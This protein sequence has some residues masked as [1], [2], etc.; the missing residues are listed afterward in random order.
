M[1]CSYHFGPFRIDTADRVLLRDG[2]PVL[3]TPKAVDVLVALLSSKGRVLDKDALL[4][5]AWPG[6]FVE[7][8]N[9]AQN[10]SLLRKALGDLRDA[11]RYIETIPKRGYRFVGTVRESRGEET[12]PPVSA[13][14]NSIAVLPFVDMSPTGDQEYLSDGLTEELIHEL[15]K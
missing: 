8:A 5:A 7:E 12:R 11:P 1:S 10:V 13:E 2:K 6:T 14:M 9:L 15:A 4:K 3:L